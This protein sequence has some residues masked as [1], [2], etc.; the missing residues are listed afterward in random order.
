MYKR[1]AHEA[2][3][4]LGV[5]QTS[6]EGAYC[7]AIKFLEVIGCEQFQRQNDFAAVCN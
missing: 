1:Q 4:L 3:F 5:D 7:A 6:V 2:A